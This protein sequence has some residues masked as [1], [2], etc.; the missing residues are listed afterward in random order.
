ME[1]KF[2]KFIGTGWEYKLWTK[3]RSSVINLAETKEWK[4]I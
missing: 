2:Y 4:A 3:Y 1:F